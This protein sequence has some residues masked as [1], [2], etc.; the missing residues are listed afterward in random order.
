MFS[1][2]FPSQV[3]D[4]SRHNPALMEEYGTLEGRVRYI[5]LDC[6]SMT[7]IDIAGL[8][9]L[10]LIITQYGRVDSTVLLSGESCSLPSSGKV[11]CL[12]ESAF[13]GQSL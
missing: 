3:F 7:Y 10:K 13:G 4:P 2:I 8:N 9:M 1:F 11:K 12:E 5:L 6:S